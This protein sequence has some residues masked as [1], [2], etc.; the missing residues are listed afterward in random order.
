MKIIPLLIVL[1]AAVLVTGRIMNNA[2]KSSPHAWC[3]PMST[4]RHHIQIGSR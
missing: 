3:A 1:I 4:E 2:C